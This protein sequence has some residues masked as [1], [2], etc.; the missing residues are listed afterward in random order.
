[1]QTWTV[2]KEES[3]NFLIDA[4]K[5]QKKPFVVEL[6]PAHRTI[7][8]NRLFYLMY[9]IIAKQLYGGDNDLARNE[10]KLTI[11]VPILRRDSAEFTKTY[12]RLIKPAT[13]EDKLSAMEFISVSS[14]FDKAQ[15]SEYVTKIFDTYAQK[16]VKWSELIIAQVGM[17]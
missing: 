11:G 5:E 1:M 12:D 6:L 14:I 17:L 3:L 15:G 13:Y 7:P 2:T 16:S 4:L 9:D 8:Q 10:C